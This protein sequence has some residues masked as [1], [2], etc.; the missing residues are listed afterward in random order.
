MSAA[1][2][3][4]MLARGAWNTCARSSIG[5]TSDSSPAPAS[6]GISTTGSVR[7]ADGLHIETRR[8]RLL[9]HGPRVGGIAGLEDE[10]DGGLADVQIKALTEMRHIDDAGTRRGHLDE[11]SR[12]SARPVG[13]AGEDDQP[14]TCAGLLAP[15]GRPE[16]ACVYVAA[17]QHYDGLARPGGSERDEAGVERRHAYG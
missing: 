9:E 14:P 17:G 5:P 1:I 12:E 3:G 7:V 4:S 11:K 16:N 2:S 15:D 8:P 6:S 13:D 10:M